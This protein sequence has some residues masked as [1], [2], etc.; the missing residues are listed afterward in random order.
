MN[1]ML[2]IKNL[3]TKEK[4]NSFIIKKSSKLA[5]YLPQNYN[6]SWNVFSEN[7]LHYAEVRVS[8]FSGPVILA[9][10]HSRNPF[11]IV[12][13]AVSKVV[14]QLKKKKRVPQFDNST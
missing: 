6:V 9:K 10:A 8:G 1:L 4:L 7:N 5:K 11:K 14:T 12:D 2:T 3:K 13:M